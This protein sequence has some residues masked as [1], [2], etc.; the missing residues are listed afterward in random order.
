MRANLDITRGLVLTEAV[1]MRL[2]PSLGR[3]EAHALVDAASRR[4]AEEGRSLA[5]V[6]AEDPA[7][8]AVLDRPA[9]DAALSPEHYLG[10]ARTFVENALGRRGSA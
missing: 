9:I 1:V 2:A 4:V 3:Q 7:V 10:C 8:T 6:L 5:E